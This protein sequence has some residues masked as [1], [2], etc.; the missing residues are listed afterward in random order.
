M[1]PISEPVFSVVGDFSRADDRL[2]VSGISPG[3]N[4]ATIPAGSTAT[5]RLPEMISGRTYPGRWTMLEVEL[6][7]SAATASASWV[8]R[9]ASAA[10]TRTV[11]DG[12]RLLLDLPGEAQ[13]VQVTTGDTETTVTRIRLVD[14]RAE[15]LKVTGRTPFS[16]S[17]FGTSWVIRGQR[18]SLNLSAMGDQPLA[19][20]EVNATRAVFEAPDRTFTAYATGTVLDNGHVAEGFT[21]DVA[22]AASIADPGDL[23][24]LNDAAT[25]VMDPAKGADGR[26]YIPARGAWRVLALGQRLRLR[27]APSTRGSAL[28]RP[29]LEIEGLQGGPPPSVNIDGQPIDRVVRTGE[30]W[31]IELPVRVVGPAVIEINQARREPD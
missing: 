4:S 18:Y 27:L 12:N 3:R 26:G 24:V 17:R 10:Q 22:L 28:I 1:P 2:F 13:A 11:R 8:H 5:I 9:E 31:L 25:L 23:S 7:P 14:N 6:V 16:V 21:R 29:V 30:V 20:T 15:V 19:P